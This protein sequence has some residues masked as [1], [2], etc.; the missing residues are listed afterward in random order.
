M[1]LRWLGHAAFSLEIGGITLCLDPHRP[2]AV[3]GR[4]ALPAIHGPFDAV[5]ISHRHE[6]HAGW[7]PALGSNRLIDHDI[8]LGPVQLRM[9]AVVHDLAA[10]TRAGLVRM[11]SVQA[12]GER[13]VHCS[14]IAAFSSAD[15]AWL[16]GTDVLLVP[17]GGTYTFDGQQAADFAR[18]VGARWTVPMHY[19]DPRIDLPLRPL[20]DFA[21]A[22]GERVVPAESLD[23]KGNQRAG[24]LSLR[25]P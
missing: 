8:D 7:T 12:A 21:R 18:Q 9:R 22:W 19:A 13:L 11:M 10:G 4:F 24:A 23:T 16:R 2:G 17:C 20:A 25:R 14:D 15:V 3:G 5:I 1:R 6:D